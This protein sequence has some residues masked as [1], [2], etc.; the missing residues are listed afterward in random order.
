MLQRRGTDLLTRGQTPPGSPQRGL[1]QLHR[2][3][4][5]PSSIHDGHVRPGSRPHTVGAHA[6]GARLSHT[7]G[8]HATVGSQ[9]HVHFPVLTAGMLRVQSDSL[10]G[11]GRFGLDVQG[12]QL[13]PTPGRATLEKAGVPGGLTSSRFA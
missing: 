4:S 2:P 7:V 5:R 13:D 3:V 11:S 8:A 12:R 10:L 1:L 9:Q 6:V